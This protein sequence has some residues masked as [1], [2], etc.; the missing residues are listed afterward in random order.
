[1]T[2]VYGTGT[3]TRSFRYVDE[4]TRTE[5]NCAYS[6]LPTDDPTQRKP[7]CHR[8]W[9]ILDWQPEVDLR[10]GLLKRIEWYAAIALLTHADAV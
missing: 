3:Q 9:V 6:Q 8:A 2:P 10:E 7:E 4:L 1:M 5:V